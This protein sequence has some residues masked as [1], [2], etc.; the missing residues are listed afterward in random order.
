MAPAA[1]VTMIDWLVWRLIDNSS[2]ASRRATIDRRGQPFHPRLDLQRDVQRVETAL[3]QIAALEPQALLCG[4][5]PH[6]A[7]L[8]FPGTGIPCSAR[9]QA[10]AWADLA[11]HFRR[12]QFAHPFAH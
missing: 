4:R 5:F 11:L 12:D 2:C 6:V 8:A 10:P 7:Q 9:A 3:H 1:P